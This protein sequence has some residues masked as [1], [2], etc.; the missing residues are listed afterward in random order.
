M[1]S[2]KTEA[3]TP[4]RI[5]DARREGQVARSQ[6]LTAAVGLLA[7]IWMLQ[8]SGGRLVSALQELMTVSLA[9]SRSLEPSLLGLQSLFTST[10]MRLAAPLGLIL[11]SLLVAGLAVNLA[12]TGF[13]FTTKRLS[14]D[15]NRLNPLAGFKRM[16]STQGL[17][18]LGKSLL[19]L[20][21]IGWVAYSSLRSSLP[22]L[23]YLGQ[24]GVKDGLAAWAGMAVDLSLRVAAC[25]LVL[26]LADYAY[27]RWQYI[28]SLR[29]SKEELKEDIKRSEGDPFIRSRIRSQQRRMARMRMMEKVPQADVIITNPTHLAVAIQYDASTMNAPR[30]VAKGADRVAYKIIEIA[31]SHDVPI[32]QNIPVARALYRKVDIDEEIPPELY[33]ALAEVLAYVYLLRS[34]RLKSGVM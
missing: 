23:V 27:Q 13:L 12:Q 2:E 28:K 19:K 17:F 9:E 32:V 6:E 33:A 34:D 15:L 20:L 26:A 29:M 8:I 21:V 31:R 7:G 10:V 14:P 30:V 3:P 11:A 16:F 4:R 18:E 5:A 22:R 24:T 1:S 25:Y